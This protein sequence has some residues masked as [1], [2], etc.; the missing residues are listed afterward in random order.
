MPYQAVAWTLRMQQ[1]LAA[2]Q[3]KSQ[4]ADLPKVI[5]SRITCWDAPVNEHNINVVYDPISCAELNTLV[6]DTG[7]CGQV[8]EI[9][10]G[11]T[12]IRWLLVLLMR[13]DVVSRPRPYLSHWRGGLEIPS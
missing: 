13:L 7:G 3:A 11:L 5:V 8:C 1:F 2:I 10:F 6:L 12:P 4:T 9:T